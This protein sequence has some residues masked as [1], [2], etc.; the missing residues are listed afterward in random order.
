VNF[1]Y[2]EQWI[3]LIYNNSKSGKVK[4]HFKLISEKDM[5]ARKSIKINEDAAII[6]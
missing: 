6:K 3:D 5:E 2:P 4:I 1:K